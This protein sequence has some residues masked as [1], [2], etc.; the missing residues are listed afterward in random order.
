[1][2]HRE[3]T[4]A[5][6]SVRNQKPAIDIINSTRQWSHIQA[7]K[8]IEPHG[9]ME[10]VVH[11]LCCANLELQIDDRNFNKVVFNYN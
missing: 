8:F 7:T 1:M 5:I 3:H 6:F 11:Y 2:T 4:F 10:L 9:R